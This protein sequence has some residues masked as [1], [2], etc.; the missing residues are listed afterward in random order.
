MDTAFFILSKLVGFALQIETWF[1]LGMALS[2][3][4]GIWMRP[5]LARWSGG[6]TLLVMVFVGILPVG[7]VLLRPLEN[8]FPPRSAPAQID[9]IVILGGVEDARTAAI[10]G[11][12]QLNEAAERI[13]GAAALA[14]QHQNAQLV[15]SGGSGRLRHS[16]SG[17]PDIPRVA[18]DVFVSLGID[19]DRII[20]E[21]RSRNT[22]ENARYS[23]EAIV[24]VPG[25]APD[26]TSSLTSGPAPGP[27][28]GPSLGPSPDE[29]WVL[30]TSA[31]HMGRA[32]ASFEAAGWEKIMPYPVDYRTGRFVDNIGWN[33]AGNLN[34]L[35][36]AI[37]EWV[38]RLAYQLTGRS[39][40]ALRHVAV[41]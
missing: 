27:S 36:L 2:L 7:E 9:G 38:G 13:T 10:W 24:P 22:A 32:L 3:A 19:P 17:R 1:A 11:T 21:D 5:R 25:L 34:T 35:N 37:K 12:P 41:H 8:A 39:K 29:T 23:F 26:F 18:V 31:F 6:L 16:L 33:L 4:G 15:F 20:W 28:L 40:I 30:V 14:I